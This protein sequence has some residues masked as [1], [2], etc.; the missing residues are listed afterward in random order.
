ML[1]GK[2]NSLK[3]AKYI[4]EIFE[5]LSRKNLVGESGKS[6]VINGY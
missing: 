2:F 4:V 5:L 1:K 6:V 3:K